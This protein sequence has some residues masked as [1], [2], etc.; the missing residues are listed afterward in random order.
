MAWLIGLVVSTVVLMFLVVT[1][2]SSYDPWVLLASLVTGT[3]YV[4]CMA[5]MWMTRPSLRSS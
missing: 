5:G 2:F 4:T 3:I 1:L